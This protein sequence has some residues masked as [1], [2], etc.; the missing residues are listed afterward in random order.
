MERMA[1]DEIITQKLKSLGPLRFSLPNRFEKKS[2][3]RQRGGRSVGLVPRPECRRKLNGRRCGGLGAFG[4]SR[5]AF[6][7]AIV[8]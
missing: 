8:C 7:A 2:F 1:R 3:L 4:G 5:P 6:G